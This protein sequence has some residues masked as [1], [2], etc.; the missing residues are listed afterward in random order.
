MLVASVD[1]PKVERIVENLIGNAAKYSTGPIAARVERAPAGVLITVDDEGP[2]VPDEAKDRI[3]EPFRRGPY[4][5]VHAPGTGIGLA[6][7]ARF[8][9]LHSGR[10]WVEDRSDGGSSFR[11]FLPAGVQATEQQGLD[12]RAATAS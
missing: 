2:G 3:F 8:A 12:A 7:V 1:G 10:A 11:V 5:R 4:V 6:L 9:E